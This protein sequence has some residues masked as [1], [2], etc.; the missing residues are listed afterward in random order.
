[1]N[2]PFILHCRSSEC[3]AR[4]GEVSTRKGSFRTPVFMPVGT[5]AAVRGLT[6]AMLKEAGAEI[7]LT[8]TYHLFL[9]PGHEL[10]S[11]LGGLHYFMNWDRPILTD[12]GG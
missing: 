3:Q 7:I 10:V 9:R 6:P 11:Q 1:M 12:S 8:N 2:S 4:C 5:R